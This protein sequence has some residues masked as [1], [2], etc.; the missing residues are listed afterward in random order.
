MARLHAGSVDVH[1]LGRFDSEFDPGSERDKLFRWRAAVAVVERRSLGRV[2]VLDLL[3]GHFAEHGA[4]AAGLAD[5]D[6][7]TLGG[8]RGAAS[9]CSEHAGA[10]ICSF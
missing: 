3:Y 9:R 2:S 1:G 7:P 10:G 8:F 6:D 5:G 4:E